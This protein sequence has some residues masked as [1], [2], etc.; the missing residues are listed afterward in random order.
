MQI[1]PKNVLRIADKLDYQGNI[2]GVGRQ[3]LDVLPQINS[4]RFRMIACTLRGDD[5]IG[6]LFGDRG[7]TFRILHRRK[8]DPL[9]L[10]NLLRIVREEGVDLLH[11]DNLEVFFWGRIIGAI[12]GKP[13][14][15]HLHDCYLEERYHWYLRWSD[16]LLNRYTGK[17]IAISEDV[18][19][20]CR[21]K[22]KLPE[23]KIKIIETGVPLERYDHFSENDR[24]ALRLKLGL[25]TN[26]PII[27]TVTR[28]HPVKGNQY[29]IEA[30]SRVLKEFPEALF[31]LVGDGP[32]R[33]KLEDQARRLGIQ[34]RIQFMGFRKDVAEILGAIDIS[35]L[36][37]LSEGLSTA[38]IEAKAAGCAIVATRVGGIPETVTDG[39]TGLLAPSGDPE[40]LADR[41]VHL[42]KNPAERRRFG[43][44]A[45][46]DSRRHDIRIHVA[47]LENLYEEIT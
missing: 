22:W 12:T 20:T 42:L 32:L 3:F 2:H 45:R 40:A 14:V 15:V 30:A 16:L 23:K 33:G 8:F 11:V 1:K 6:K 4:S 36:S 28:F 43:E 34:D 17:V 27:G 5:S 18:A 7:L 41:I 39:H 10:L 35:V 9:T 44:A 31:I 25:P 46:K 38:L 21:K 26:A 47:K 24:P 29:L 37:S 13:V 19:E